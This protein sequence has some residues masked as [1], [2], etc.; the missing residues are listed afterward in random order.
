MTEEEKTSEQ[1]KTEATAKALEALSQAVVEE[2][3]SKKAE[4]LGARTRKRPVAV[5]LESPRVLKDLANIPRNY[6]T[7]PKVVEAAE[8]GLEKTQKQIIIFYQHAVSFGDRL[9]GLLFVLL[10]LSILSAGILAAS[11]DLFTIQDF[12]AYLAITGIG[13][14]LMVI[15]GVSLFAYGLSKLF[16]GFWGKMNEMKK[17]KVKPKYVQKKLSY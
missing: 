14:I 9:R 5:L 17:K 11:V 6:L 15:V 3:E 12:L 8:Q 1:E 10:G 16:S 13:Q 4:S 2:L 7:D